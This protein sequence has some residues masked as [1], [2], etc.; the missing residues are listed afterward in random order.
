[1]LYEHKKLRPFGE[2]SRMVNQ[3]SNPDW[4]S[5]LWTRPN[6]LQPN[7]GNSVVIRDGTETQL[8]PDG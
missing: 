5:H 7:E 6:E 8:V 4:V 2:I 1:M 3:D